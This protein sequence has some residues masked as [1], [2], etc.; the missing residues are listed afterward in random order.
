MAH[1][2]VDIAASCLIE[3]RGEI[4]LVAKPRLVAAVDR[5][6]KKAAPLAQ[7]AI[8][9]LVQFAIFAAKKWNAEEAAREMIA[10]ACRATQALAAQA[11]AAERELGGDGYALARSAPQFGAR[12]RH[13]SLPNFALLQHRVPRRRA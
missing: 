8:R 1:E 9:E 6:A 2:L 11:H 3:A 12:G 10:V 4:V 13:G 7:E 5:W